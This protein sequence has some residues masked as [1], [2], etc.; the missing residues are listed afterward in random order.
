MNKPNRLWSAGMDNMSPP[1][2]KFFKTFFKNNNFY[3]FYKTKQ[4]LIMQKIWTTYTLYTY[5]Q[6][7]RI[8]GM[9]MIF[10]FVGIGI[11]YKFSILSW[12]ICN[13]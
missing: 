1:Q 9:L 11:L 4:C 2:C 3:V 12:Q 5:L 7:D 13:K 6:V 10:N 8:A